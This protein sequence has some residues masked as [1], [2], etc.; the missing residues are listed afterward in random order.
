MIIFLL[1]F[2][3]ACQQNDLVVS[4]DDNAAVVTSQEKEPNW[5]QLPEMDEASLQKSYT[6]TKSI[7]C[8]DGGF[9][10]MRF[11][12]TGPNGY[13]EAYSRIDFPANAWD[14]DIYGESV[15][16]S[17]KLDDGT[18]SVTFNP[19]M[20]FENYPTLN[21]YFYGL[22]LTNVDVNEIQFVYL[23][24][25]G[26]YENITMEDFTVL[27]EYGY[28]SVKNAKIPHFSRFGFLN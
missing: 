25:D 21:M 7:S 18:V 12:Y 28:L 2:L 14:S 15:A 11:W 26:G 24:P 8:D 5:L 4:P 16:I 13:V 27:P 23:A 17:M 20:T 1:G 6:W 10:G 22:D 19:H 3:S 9:M